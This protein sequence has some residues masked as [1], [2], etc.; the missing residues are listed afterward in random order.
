MFVSTFAHVPEPH[1]PVHP[2]QV[3]ASPDAHACQQVTD[4]TVTIMMDGSVKERDECREGR[5]ERLRECLIDWRGGE[6]MYAFRSRSASNFTSPSYSTPC[7]TLPLPSHHSPFTL[8]FLHPLHPL[9]SESAR[10]DHPHPL[11]PL[12][13]SWSSQR[14]SPPLI[15][16]H[17]PDRGTPARPPGSSRMI[18]ILLDPLILVKDLA[19][20][21]RD[22]TFSCTG[23]DGAGNQSH[24]PLDPDDAGLQCHPHQL[25]SGPCPYTSAMLLAWC[26]KMLCGGQCIP[27]PTH[28]ALESALP[29][30]SRAAFTRTRGHLHSRDHRDDCFRR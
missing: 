27:L 17:V 30:C 10:F 3:R 29:L 14:S 26:S 28:N 23:A 19:Y 4:A 13:W 21:T 25:R 5:R 7:F 22:R 20:L 12:T 24:L 15:L 11:D 18:P 16:S 6:R 9:A 2:K 1:V 8:R